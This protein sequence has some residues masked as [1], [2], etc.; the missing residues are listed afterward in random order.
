VA[1]LQSYA[2]GFSQ[3]LTHNYP[4]EGGTGGGDVG[5]DAPNASYDP[6]PATLPVNTGGKTAGVLQVEGQSPIPL[7]SGVNGPSQAI[8]G[9]GLP[10]FNGNQLTHV[11]GHAAAYM[12]SNG[13]MSGVLD[14]NKVPCTAGSGGGCEGLL[15][16][17]LPGGATLRVRG[18]GGYDRIFEGLPD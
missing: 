8:R 6:A 10:G 5:V 14:I 9:Q 4:G 12:R 7:V 3:V 16:K 15:P 1:E 2:V 13:I 18:P 17:M 11:E